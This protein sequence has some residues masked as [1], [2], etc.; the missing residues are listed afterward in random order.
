M[1]DSVR[2]LDTFTH[3]TCNYY[4]R[5]LD[6]QNMTAY[7]ANTMTDDVMMDDDDDDDDGS[8]DHGSHANSTE[9]YVYG[10]RRFWLARA[11]F[12][13]Y[14]SISYGCSASRAQLR[15]RTNLA[16]NNNNNNK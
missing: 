1:A 10:C 7:F 12:I 2:T 11:T 8:H 9:H 3:F 13:I 15:A 14:F 16:N 5:V 4:S 6:T